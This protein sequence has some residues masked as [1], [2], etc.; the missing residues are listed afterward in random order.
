MNSDNQSYENPILKEIPK[1]EDKHLM[2]TEE[3]QRLLN[4]N[5]MLK[6]KNEEV[7]RTIAAKL[8]LE[9]IKTSKKKLTN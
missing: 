5:L 8:L 1:C 7:N 2:Y 6:K 9:N 4:E 3:I